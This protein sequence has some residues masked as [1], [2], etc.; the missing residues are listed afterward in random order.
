MPIQKVFL[1]AEGVYDRWLRLFLD[2]WDLLSQAS[3][4]LSAVA[5]AADDDHF[6][7][8]QQAVK[9]GRGQ[10]R[11]QE[12]VGP[13]IGG[14]VA[15]E[16]DAAALVALVNH[17]IQVFGAR[18]LDRFETEIIQD[19]Q[20]G[21]QVVAQPALPGAICPATVEVLEH[22][23]D[24]HEKHIKAL[25]GGFLTKRLSQ[26]GFTH[27]GRAADQQVAVLADVFAGGQLQDLLAVEV[28]I[29]LE[30]KAFNGFGSIR[31]CCGAGAC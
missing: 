13:L 10:E 8:I 3:A 28:G 6:G 17:I 21:A 22:F 11:I 14:A 4:A 18:R 29:E 30:I 25:A 23:L 27:P 31:A 20:I 7:A 19:E 1:E 26:M 2:S 9:P 24:A 15:G 5:G 16:Q 12:Q